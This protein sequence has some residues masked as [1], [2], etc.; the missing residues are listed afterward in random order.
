MLVY[1]DQPQQQIVNGMPRFHPWTVTA[2]TPDGRYVDF[3]VSPELIS[4]AL[5]DLPRVAGSKAESAIVDFIMWANGPNSIFE[6]NDFGMRPL[7]KNESG[8]SPSAMEL[9]SRITILFRDLRRNLGANLHGFATSLETAI[10]TV[11]PDF[12]Q[13]CWSWC[14]WPHLF[15]PI[16]LTGQEPRGTVIALQVWAWGDDPTEVHANMAR[17][18]DNLRAALEATSCHGTPT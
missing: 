16:E 7:K 18:Y 15:L 1:F 3:K 2:N 4:S 6:T 8:A 11:D 13:A 9:L 10:K 17:A 5:E 12:R 14:L